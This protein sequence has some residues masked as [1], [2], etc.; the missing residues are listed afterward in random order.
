[1]KILGD[2]IERLSDECFTDIKWMTST[3]EGTVFLVD[4]RSLKKIDPSGDTEIVVAT[5]AEQT[6]TQPTLNERHHIMGIW[7]D[8][9]ANVYAAVYGAG[10]VKKISCDGNVTDFLE[11]SVMWSPTGGLLAANGDFWLLEC[12]PTNRV[13][14]ER[15]TA[16]GNRIIYSSKQ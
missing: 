6:T 9:R 2:R 13:R 7:T 11:T 12:A 15:I 1:V 4:Q 10:R 3:K 5:L 14:V 8:P 16:D